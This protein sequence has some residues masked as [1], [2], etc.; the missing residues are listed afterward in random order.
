[1]IP[2]RWLLYI[3]EVT[4]EITTMEFLIVRDVFAI[5]GVIS[6]IIGVVIVQMIGAIAGDAIVI[7]AIAAK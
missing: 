5:I 2:A 7:V 3:V 6:I 4:V 1:M